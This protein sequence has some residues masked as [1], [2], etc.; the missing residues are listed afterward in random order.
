V[1]EASS[2]LEGA[3]HEL[4]QEVANGKTFWLSSSRSQAVAQETPTA[5]LMSIYDEYISAY[6]DRSAMADE[7]TSARLVGLGN[8]L[9][10]VVVLDG[11]IVGT[12]K[13][14]GDRRAADAAIDV[15]R[16]LTRAE[17]GAVSTALNKY[18][19]FMG[20]GRSTQQQQVS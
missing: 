10:H 8:A 11:R 4:V 7:A 14:A 13:P 2:G 3:R 20:R 17:S 15:F 18:L 16:P 5:H 1:T 9:T 19:A 6:K 12:W